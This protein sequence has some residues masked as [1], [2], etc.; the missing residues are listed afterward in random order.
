MF[1]YDQLQEMA[2]LG[3]G[4]GGLKLYWKERKK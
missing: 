3:G 4:G 1:L 2:L